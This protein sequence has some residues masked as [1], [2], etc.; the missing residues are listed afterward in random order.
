MKNC[1]KYVSPMKEARLTIRISPKNK[2]KLSSLAKQ[3]GLTISDLM[4][5]KIQKMLDDFER[6]IIEDDIKAKVYDKHMR[7]EGFKFSNNNK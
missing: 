4:N 7:K 3:N 5:L 2:G 1:V 6:G